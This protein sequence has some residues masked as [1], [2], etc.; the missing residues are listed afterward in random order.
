MKYLVVSGAELAQINNYYTNGAT[1]GEHIYENLTLE[2]AFMLTVYYWRYRTNTTKVSIILDILRNGSYDTI[3]DVFK[4]IAVDT[5]NYISTINLKGEELVSGS[6]YT[7]YVIAYVPSTVTNNIISKV[8]SNV[9]KIAY[10][11]DA[12]RNIVNNVT[13]VLGISSF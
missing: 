6:S 10:D 5:P 13:S 3:T 9:I 4:N 8:S 2:E 11:V 7:D 1:F 12:D